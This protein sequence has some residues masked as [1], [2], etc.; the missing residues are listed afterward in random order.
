MND[1]KLR[2]ITSNQYLGNGYIIETIDGHFNTMWVAPRFKD[3]TIDDSQWSIV[4]DEEVINTVLDWNEVEVLEVITVD[5][6]CERASLM[7][8]KAV[9]N[10]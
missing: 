6:F 9:P 10:E 7:K 5:E 4:E 1:N 8:P 2:I 3:G